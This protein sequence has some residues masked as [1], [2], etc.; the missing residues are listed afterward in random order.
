[1]GRSN[2]GRHRSKK[3]RNAGPRASGVIEINPRGFGFVETEDA[4]F[5]IPRGHIHG[6]LPGDTVELKPRS[7]RTGAGKR[8]TA[9]VARVLERASEYITGTLDRRGPLAIVTPS[10]PRVQYDMFVTYDEDTPAQDGDTVLARIVNFPGKN[11]S[12]EGH[13]VQVLASADSPGTDIDVIIH[14]AGLQIEFSHETIEQTRTIEPD[15]EGALKQEGRQDLRERDVFTIDPSDAKDLDDALSLERVEGMW[16]LGVHIADVSQYVSWNSPVDL[17]ARARAASTYLVDRVIPMLPEKLSNDICSLQP[18]RERCTMTCDMFFDE[19]AHLV[20]YE[21][22]PSV[23]RSHRRFSYEEAAEILALHESDPYRQ[24]LSWLSGLTKKMEA[25]R[26][27][28]GALDFDSADPH[29]VLDEEGKPVRIDMRVKNPAT[30]L[31]EEAMIAANRTVATH[32]FE[33]EHAL[34]YRVHEAPSSSALSV[35]LPV[36]KYLGYPIEGLGSGK[37]AP[38]QGVLERAKGTEEEQLVHNL[39]LRSMEQ[40]YYTTSQEGHFGLALSHYCH[41]TSPIRRYP[42]LM[43]HR[44]LKDPHAM[45]G[46]LDELAEHASKKERDIEKVERDCTMLK[47]SEFMEQKVGDEFNGQ[48]SRVFA[49]SFLV[50]LD[51][52]FEGT[53]ELGQANEEYFYFDAQAQTLEGEESGRVFRLGQRVGVRLEDVLRHSRQGVFSLI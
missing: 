8:R 37:P 43:V 28:A 26:V 18:G 5:Y 38:F 42:D 4:S 39:V 14:G 50:R 51:N 9:S 2:K 7:D 23:I 40:A 41:F 17:D 10:D 24:K 53:V 44:L 48:I 11:N 19:D 6:A 47:I 46:K 32:M 36:L 29:P 1:M 35:L 25:L 21:I 31:V 16:R 20:R 49:H 45:Q 13:V 34:V 33:H 22:Y 15:I 12:L 27:K 30:S 3:G 52:T